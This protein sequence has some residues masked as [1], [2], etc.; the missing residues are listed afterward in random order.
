MESNPSL[1][2]I[3][4]FLR[5]FFDILEWR[6]YGGQVVDLVMPCLRPGW[7]VSEDGLPHIQALLAI[8]EEELARAPESTHYLVAFGR[9]RGVRGLARPLAAQARKAVLRRLGRLRGR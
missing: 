1:S 3:A 5:D 6:P 8:E 4:R 9:L 2:E 7:A